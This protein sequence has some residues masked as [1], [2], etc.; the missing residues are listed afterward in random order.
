MSAQATIR[1]EDLPLILA[2][3]KLRRR[4]NSRACQLCALSEHPVITV[5]CH[6]RVDARRRAQAAALRFGASPARCLPMQR[7]RI[8]DLYERVQR[9][10][11]RREVLRTWAAGV[12]ALL[13]EPLHVLNGGSAVS[14]A[15]A[16][17]RSKT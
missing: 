7:G 8:G 17:G 15:C 5:D 10:H 14:S 3:A 1:A 16:E 9:T 2:A 11:G 12:R 13:G 6:E 4:N